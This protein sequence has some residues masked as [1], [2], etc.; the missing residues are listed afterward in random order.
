MAASFSLCAARLL[1]SSPALR[2]CPRAAR[3]LTPRYCHGE[4]RSSTQRPGTPR[5]SLYEHVREG[6][7][8]KPELDMT[9][10]CADP[11]AAVVNVENRKGE[12]RGEDVRK[13][14]SLWQQLEAVRA[15]ISSLEEQKRNISDTVKTLVTNNEK[16]TLAT[17]PAYSA[18]RQRGREVRHRL[19][20]LTPKESELEEQF[21]SRALKLPNTTH[22]DVGFIPLTVPDMLKAAVFEGCGMQPHAHRSQVYSVDP[23]QNPDLNLAGTGEVGIAGFFM[24]HAVSWKDLP[25]RTVC[26]S[27]CYRAETDTGRETWG[28]YRVHHFNKV[29][30]FGVTADES[31]QESADMLQEFVSLQKELFSEL[32]LHFRVL[33]MPT[34]EL[35]PPAH[36]KFDIEAWMP[37]RNSY[38]EISSGSNCTDYQSRR[39][40]IVYEREDGSL[41]YAH[42]VNAT[43]CAIPRMIISILET[44]QTKDGSVLIPKALQ[45]FF[46]SDLIQK[47]SYSALKYIGPN[48]AHRPPR[49][50]PKKEE[51]KR[52]R[53][54]ERKS[55]EK[56][57]E[58][59]EREKERERKREERKSKERKRERKSEERKRREK[60]REKERGEK[61]GEKEERERE[62]ERG[63]K[64]ERKRKSEERKRRRERGEKGGEK[65]GRERK[66]KERKS[67]E[68]KRERKSE[69]RKR[70]RKSEER[71]RERKSEERK[72]ERKSKER[73]G[74]ERKRERKMGCRPL[75]SSSLKEAKVDCIIQQTLSGDDSQDQCVPQ[76]A[77][78]LQ[79]VQR[80]HGLLQELQD[81]AQ[82]ERKRERDDDRDEDEDDD[83]DE[84][85]EEEGYNRDEEDE[86]EDDE[87]DEDDDDDERE[88]SDEEE[89]E[90]TELM[91][92]AKK[93][94]N[95]DDKQQDTEEAEQRR[96][97]E[98]EL[99]VEKEKVQKELQDLQ[100]KP[101][102][103]LRQSEVEKKTEELKELEA[104]VQRVREEEEKEEE[105]RRRKEEEEERTKPSTAAPQNQTQTNQTEPVKS[106][107]EVKPTETETVSDNKTEQKREMEKASDEATRQFEREKQEKQE[108]EEEEEEDGREDER[109]DD[110]EEEREEDQD[111]DEGEELLEIES[112]LRKVASE[113][114]ALRRG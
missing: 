27:T 84:E 60:E 20:E 4:A 77:E 85:E 67:E 26:C 95:Y 93:K 64:E 82:R 28:L 47:P 33:D 50:A 107:A 66:S 92:E 1:G 75:S 80:H 69:E 100:N 111:E 34:Q 56:E 72:R 52:E 9:R 40:N 6:Y 38:G 94:K 63:E 98:V 30:M 68:R 29:E 114:R 90:V 45:P 5:S 51:R 96:K 103:E 71:K 7:S 22:P 25:V 101:A 48:Q 73:K 108:E 17:L 39:L 97:S 8:D 35:G 59:E 105:K 2:L 19:N 110:R 14:V 10:V 13:I 76:L 86:G 18:A 15:E 89:D 58:K 53:K 65:R 49:P 61:E 83:D 31:G 11:E 36:R 74:E 42:T 88:R 87:D 109:E 81:L 24:D 21:Y 78:E 62:E 55:E 57:G 54:S 112:E 46:G 44:H 32:E 99:L 23:S 104:K 113:L 106:D 12:L 43:A 79:Q 41:Q 16:K 37:G 91:K 102:A 3:A 70:E